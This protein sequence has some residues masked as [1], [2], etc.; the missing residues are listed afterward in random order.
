MASSDSCCRADACSGQHLGQ[1]ALR[2]SPGT[3]DLQDP[4]DRCG[5]LQC[6][7]ATT[8]HQAA[9]DRVAFL[10][11]GATPADAVLLQF[12][13]REAGALQPR[14]GFG[15]EELARAGI[16]LDLQ[17]S[18][19]PLPVSADEGQLRQVFLN[20][21]RNAREAMPTG[22]TLTL[23]AAPR[24]GELEIQVIDTGVGMGPEVR[25]KLFEPFFTTK[26]GGTGLGLPLSRQIVE[27]HGGRIS[28]DSEPGRGTTF[29]LH[30]PSA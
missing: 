26:Q 9:G 20:L 12:P 18:P 25:E 6:L 24:N 11:V 16:T 1:A 2:H 30:L 17:L 28:V 22:G 10:T 5:C 29:H 27:A 15:R 23:R 21:V 13:Y 4:A 19:G 7:K 3:G 8:G 14:A